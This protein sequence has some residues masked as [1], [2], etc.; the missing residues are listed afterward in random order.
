[1]KILFVM[2]Q[3]SEGNNGITISTRR[4]ASYLRKMGHIVKVLGVCPEGEDIFVV[5]ERRVP[6]ATY[7]AHKQGLVF[8][9][10][11]ESVVRESMS[12]VDIVHFLMPFYLCKKGI[13]IAKEMNVPYTGAFH[14]QPENVS[15]NIGLHWSKSIVKLLYKYFYLTF[16]RYFS[17]IHCP[18]YFIAN[19]LKSHGYDAKLHIISNGIDDKFVYHKTKKPKELEDKFIITMIGRLS[20]EK[21]QDVLMKAVSKSKYSDQ[22]QVMYAGK[23]PKAKY[24]KKIA[25][26]LPINPP[27][28]GFYS[29]EELL[30]I[31]GYTDLYVHSA[32]VEI[33]AIACIE[34]FATG[35]V[36]VISN[37]DASA[38]PQFARDERSLFEK[39]NIQDLANKI[40]YWIEHEE[41]RKR[42]EYVYAEY[43][44]EFNIRKSV[45]KMIDM[46]EEA[47]E[48]HKKNS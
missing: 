35:L 28:F 13:K 42:M 18:S 10:P 38:T 33:E 30:N 19:Q 24:Y 48:D 31:L 40:D 4:F 25:D 9:K 37:S 43:A 20:L 14:I 23:G 17:H 1:M 39:G 27:I 46:F 16:Y 2:D 6:L 41:E 44:K 47:I 22:I 21:R 3:Y 7:F 26:K 32:D 45:S 12:D 15:Y 11:V 5:P 29:Q 36:P 8:G 34:A